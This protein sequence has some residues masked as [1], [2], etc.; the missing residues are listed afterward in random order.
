MPPRLVYVGLPT[1]ARFAVES[2]IPCAILPQFLPTPHTI[3]NAGACLAEDYL[4]QHR[5]AIF[6]ISDHIGKYCILA[7][8]V[9]AAIHCC[10]V[11][12]IERVSI[13]C[14][15]AMDQVYCTA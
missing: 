13:D 8:G 9:Q 6:L 5:P 10:F 2:T 14:E 15:V 4:R 7:I 3:D 1:F 12:E 11:E